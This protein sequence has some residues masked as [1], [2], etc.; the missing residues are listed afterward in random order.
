MSLIG[1]LGYTSSARAPKY[2]QADVVLPQS[3]FRVNWSMKKGEVEPIGNMDIFKDHRKDDPETPVIL[4]R[5]SL[6][7]GAFENVRAALTY[8]P[9]AKLRLTGTELYCR[10]GDLYYFSLENPGS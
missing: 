2:K 8:R 4:F 7:S 9:Q 1:T 10:T 5:V 6:P 3:E